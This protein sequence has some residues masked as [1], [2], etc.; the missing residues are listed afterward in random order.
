M[1]VHARYGVP[2]R[3][4]R[5]KPTSCIGTKYKISLQCGKIVN[6]VL[7]GAAE[8]ESVTST[9]VCIDSLGGRSMRLNLRKRPGMED[10]DVLGGDEG[11]TGRLSVG[12]LLLDSIELPLVSPGMLLGLMVWDRAVYQRKDSPLW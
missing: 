7:Q 1:L 12:L 8:E 4:Q 2:Q 3:I 10:E 11:E 9:R 5:C 6:F